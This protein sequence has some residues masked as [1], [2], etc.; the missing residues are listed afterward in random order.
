MLDKLITRYFV[1]SQQQGTNT[2]NPS[3]THVSYLRCNTLALESTGMWR[4][5]EIDSA[6]PQKPFPLSHK[7][8]NMMVWQTN[9][10]EAQVWGPWVEDLFLWW[11]L[12]WSSYRM[13][14]TPSLLLTNNRRSLLPWQH[15]CYHWLLI[16]SQFPVN[17]FESQCTLTIKI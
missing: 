4:G 10:N 13:L 7:H 15:T 1:W 17:I 14:Y 16:R 6:F 2:P 9:N 8:L 5:R 11:E 3:M 12:L